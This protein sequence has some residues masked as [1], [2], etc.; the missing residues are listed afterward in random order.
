MGRSTVSLEL[1]L[2]GHSFH[3]TSISSVRDT[4]SVSA[5]VYWTAGPRA[6]G[7][8]KAGWTREESRRGRQAK[9][10]KEEPFLGL[11]LSIP[12]AGRVG[13]GKVWVTRRCP[14]DARDMLGLRLPW[15][16]L[17][18]RG[19]QA[20]VLTSPGLRGAWLECTTSQHPSP[21]AA[22]GESPAL[23]SSPLEKPGPRHGKRVPQGRPAPAG[24]DELIATCPL[25]PSF[26]SSSDF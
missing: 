18:D 16:V 5:D 8:I 14:V 13:T 19:S 7:Q 11:G 10:K 9:R 6:Q 24:K 17:G 23:K 25:F 4:G 22:S 12:R 2:T 26:P 20:L 15:R 1:P 3:E 21:G